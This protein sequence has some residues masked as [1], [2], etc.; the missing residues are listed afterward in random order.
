MT[1]GR[2]ITKDQRRLFLK[3]LFEN[4][5]NISKTCDQTGLLHGTIYKMVYT[6]PDR[7][8]EFS[9]AVKAIQ[10]HNE[11]KIVEEAESSLLDNLRSRK[12]ISTIFALKAYAGRTETGKV[13]PNAKM[14]GSGVGSA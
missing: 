9:K 12:E 1:R 3:L 11:Q 4:D 2:L 13:D 7:D 14:G 6:Y 10:A 8:P 5:G